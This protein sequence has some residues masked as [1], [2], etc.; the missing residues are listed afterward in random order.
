MQPLSCNEGASSS[1]Y[2]TPDGLYRIDGTEMG[3]VCSPLW[4]DAGVRDSDGSVACG[5]LLGSGAHGAVRLGQHV[6]TGECECSHN[7]LLPL[8]L[9][10]AA[11]CAVCTHSPR[12]L[13]DADAAACVP[14]PS[15]RRCRQDLADGRGALCVQ[16]DDC[17]HPAG[18]PSHCQAS[19]RAGA[20]LR[21]CL[22]RQLLGHDPQ[23]SSEVAELKPHSPLV[24]L[25]PRSTCITK[26]ST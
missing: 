7:S 13:A 23:C 5:R 4:F 26:G 20:S 18:S 3:C 8:S 14:A 21:P 12:E 10:S 2:F 22:H 9:W 6:Q 11:P 16:G 1:Q 24:P 15:R 17:A 25:R 19:W